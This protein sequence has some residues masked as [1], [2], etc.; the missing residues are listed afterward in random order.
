[1]KKTL[2]ALVIATVGATVAI[3]SYASSERYGH[4]ENRMEHRIERMTERLNLTV[5]QQGQI[6]SLFEQQQE[7]YKA[8]RQQMQ[9]NIRSVLNDEQKTTFD[10]MRSRHEDR[11][12]Q[13][14][15]KHDGEH[16]RHGKGYAERKYEGR[17]DD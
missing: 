10:E 6:K 4:H 17:D 1:M 9:E 3:G 2:I 12:K 11:M 13:R 5:E 8:A 14:L 7:A 16:C 15:A